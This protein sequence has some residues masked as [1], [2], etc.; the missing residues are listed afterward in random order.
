[1][2]LSY[3][4]T[5]GEKGLS[6][7]E[8]VMAGYASDGGM[9]LPETIP[10][11]SSSQ[12]LHWL[13]QIETAEKRESGSA[14]SSFYA[15]LCA[16][17]CALFIDETEI[18]REDL[19][20]LVEETFV[21]A[22]SS[23]FAFCEDE[24][25]PI[26][27]LEGDQASP[28]FLAELFNG[29]SL[30]FKDLGLQFL[31]NL[32]QYLLKRR[33][34][35]AEKNAALKEKVPEHLTLLV[36]TSGDTGSA[37][38]EAVRDKAGM[39]IIVCYPGNGRISSMQE[40]Q[41]TTIKATN[42]HAL[43]VDAN[44]DDIDVFVKQLFEDLPFKKKHGISSLNS[45]NWARIM[46]QI[47]HYFYCYF[48]V[49][50]R[51]QEKQEVTEESSLPTV[52]FAI[53]SG[54]FGNATAGFIAQKM[55]LPIELL[56]CVNKNDVLHQYF[57]NGRL[58]KADHVDTTIAPSMDI[59]VPY[60]IERFF[61][62]TTGDPSQVTLRIKAL[63]EGKEYHNDQPSSSS[64]TIQSCAVSE[65]EIM[66]TIRETHQNCGYLLDPHSAV[67]VFGA[68]AV[69]SSAPTCCL[70]TA[71]PAKFAETVKRST[72]I[73]PELPSFLQDIHDRPICKRDIRPDEDPAQ[74]LRQVIETLY[75][76]RHQQPSS[77]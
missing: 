39:D 4:S 51:L 47:V 7:V 56:V 9:I 64:T 17:L 45:V 34:D 28:L 54:G 21:D 55:G 44:S 2:V 22:S 6:F 31:G 71:H 50:H 72:G 52:R 77:E 11:L 24:L 59:G 8:A 70:L 58:K 73:D 10:P 61:Y 12:L 68:R 74:V 49:V 32:L 29:P 46:I 18:P 25:I 67:G 15:Q 76:S 48:Q 41:M 19:C 5:R 16:Q 30:A 53:P 3:V 37:A 27:S 62:I 35:E 66:K 23:R 20:S 26:V 63:N 40:L 36:A 65:D 38:M 75:A 1:M 69:V 57:S 14:S 60:N 13:Q 33:N 42:V 43:S